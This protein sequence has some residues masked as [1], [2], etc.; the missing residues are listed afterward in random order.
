MPGTVAYDAILLGV[1]YAMSDTK[2]SYATPSLIDDHGSASPTFSEIFH[3]SGAPCTPWGVPE[4]AITVSSLRA[5]YAK[6]GTDVLC[7]GVVLL[8]ARYAMSGTETP[9]DASR[10]LHS[11]SPSSTF[12]SR[13]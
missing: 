13:V 4:I 11:Y 5:C 9:Y 12:A 1:C 6:S 2:L 7:A 8:R 10:S 3:G